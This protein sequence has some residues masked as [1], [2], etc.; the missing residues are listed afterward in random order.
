MALVMPA[1]QNPSSLQPAIV[2]A[3][4]LCT[5][6]NYMYTEHAKQAAWNAQYAGML[7]YNVIIT[8]IN[9]RQIS[10]CATVVRFRLCAVNINVDHYTQRSICSSSLEAAHGD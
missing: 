3:S 5:I 1:H 4:L 10:A 9:S 7:M 2:D 6:L 8:N